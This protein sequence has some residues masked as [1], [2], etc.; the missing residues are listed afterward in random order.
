MIYESKRI[1]MSIQ[2]KSKK[3]DVNG[4]LQN[5]EWLHNYIKSKQKNCKYV[6]FDI[7]LLTFLELK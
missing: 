6:I 5:N 1:I 4:T 7:D 2:A 3:S